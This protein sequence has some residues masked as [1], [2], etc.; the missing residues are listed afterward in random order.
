MVSSLA[1]NICDLWYLPKLN[2]GVGKEVS[3]QT[4]VV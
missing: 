1:S 2:A 4:T 3:V